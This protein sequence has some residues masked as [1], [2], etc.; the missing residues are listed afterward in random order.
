MVQARAFIGRKRG[1]KRSRRRS[2]RRAVAGTALLVFFM[3]LMTYLGAFSSNER[4]IGDAR[5]AVL[6]A[7]KS[8]R[9][10]PK[11][12]FAT[13]GVL[14]RSNG[15]TVQSHQI[16]VVDVLSKQGYD[17]DLYAFDLVGER[18]DNEPIDRA[19]VTR[20]YGGVDVFEERLDAEVD[21]ELDALCYDSKCTLDLSTS[22]ARHESVAACTPSKCSFQG[23]TSAKHAEFAKMYTHPSVERNCVRQIYSASRVANYIRSSNER[24]EV[25]VALS[26][27]FF[28]AYPLDPVQIAQAA[29]NPKLLFTSSHQ[30]THGGVS[31]GFYLAR[32]ETV[33]DLLS[34]FDRLAHTLPTPYNFENHLREEIDRLGLERGLMTKYDKYRSIAKVRHTGGL[35]GNSFPWLESDDPLVKNLREC[36]NPKRLAAIRAARDAATRHSRK[37]TVKNA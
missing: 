32:P 34:R 16:N 23:G 4:G 11:A 28:L 22:T 10:R 24:Y 29:S 14:G 27:D 7:S 30:D 9:R 17:V 12:L 15:C 8:W 31:N 25:V 21:A 33:V 36:L 2:A 3:W 6:S 13:Y 1:S 20:Q 37:K 18:V 5:D 35:N 26:P 19:L